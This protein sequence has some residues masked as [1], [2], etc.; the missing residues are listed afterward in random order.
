MKSNIDDLPTIKEV[1]RQLIDEVLERSGGNQSMAARML[2]I[3]RQTLKNKI[4][5]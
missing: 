3:T 2:G 1:E 4:N 5:G